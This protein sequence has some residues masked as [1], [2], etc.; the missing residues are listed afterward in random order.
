[1]SLLTTFHN[2]FKLLLLFLLLLFVESLCIVESFPVGEM[3]SSYPN[4][5][6]VQYRNP[7]SRR[8]GM[9][10]PLNVQN[11][12]KERIQLTSHGSY[13]IKYLSCSAARMLM[14][15]ATLHGF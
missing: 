4:H 6:A 14:P 12:C 7:F 15:N 1:M 3:R 9:I 13:E 10:F 5:P 11:S 8:L 2:N